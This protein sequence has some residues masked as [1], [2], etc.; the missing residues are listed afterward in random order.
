MFDQ[1]AKFAILV[2]TCKIPAENANLVG[3]SEKLRDL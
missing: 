1:I 2:Q 3:I